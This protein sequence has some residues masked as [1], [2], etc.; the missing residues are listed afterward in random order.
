MKKLRFVCVF[1]VLLVV[2]AFGFVG[3]S[4][5]KLNTENVQKAERVQEQENKEI[6]QETP[7]TEE[8]T[9]KAPVFSVT[10]VWETEKWL[11]LKGFVGENILTGWPA[12]LSRE[13]GEKLW[14]FNDQQKIKNTFLI[15]PKG[16]W[17][18]V[19]YPTDWQE[20]DVGVIFLDPQGKKLGATK[21]AQIGYDSIQKAEN[22]QILFYNSR[23]G[24]VLYSVTPQGTK[25][26]LGIS[27]PE[28]SKMFSIRERSWYYVGLNWDVCLM[29][30]MQNIGVLKRVHDPIAAFVWSNQKKKRIALNEVIDTYCFNAKGMMALGGV[31]NKEEGGVSRYLINL[32]IYDNKGNLVAAINDRPLSDF[33]PGVPE[34]LY[35]RME[36]KAFSEEWLLVQF[37]K[38]DTYKY[39]F[40][41]DPIQ[42]RGVLFNTKLEKQNVAILDEYGLLK[43]VYDLDNNKIN[44]YLIKDDILYGIFRNL[45]GSNYNSSGDKFIAWDLRKNR[46]LWRL[47]NY[48]I[49]CFDVS[50][51]GKWLVAEIEEYK[52]YH[53][54]KIVL[55]SITQQ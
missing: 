49:V 14:A 6:S 50:N 7:A 11:P 29:D 22:G 30:D 16:D 8:K 13:N 55:F 40:S 36:I 53:R 9:E 47:E 18:G 45:G 34:D 21:I 12:I 20:K 24:L 27:Y 52:P 26:V 44:N 25:K 1:L 28:L 17:V 39:S 15:G 37:I 23:D 32:K 31:I 19:C 35:F 54:R 33:I 38:I 5:T 42:S 46:E 51:D 3:C 41:F 48:N 4:K 43:D 10:P 2:F